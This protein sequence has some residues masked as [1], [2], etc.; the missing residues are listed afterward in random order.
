[1]QRV[2][3]E[4]DAQRNRRLFLALLEGRW[5]IIEDT[6]RTEYCGIGG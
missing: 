5:E 1:M 2:E 4:R 6:T 3:L